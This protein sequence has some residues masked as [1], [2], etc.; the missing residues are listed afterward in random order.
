MV[1]RRLLWRWLWGNEL[2]WGEGGRILLLG[3]GRAWWARGFCRGNS[4]W[5]G[6]DILGDPT[7]EIE[8]GLLVFLEEWVFL[9]GKIK[10]R[11]E[12]ENVRKETKEEEE[13]KDKPEVRRRWT[14]YLPA[15]LGTGTKMIE[16]PP[17]PCLLA[18]REYPSAQSCPAGPR[19]QG[20]RGPPAFSPRPRGK[21]ISPAQAQ[22]LTTQGSRCQTAL[23]TISPEFFRA[24]SKWSQ[25]MAEEFWEK[26]GNT[27][28][29][30]RHRSHPR[31]TT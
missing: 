9:R 16:V 17:R 14:S 8:R 12:E 2:W 25:K 23:N 10:R 19:I 1:W 21:G 22:V 29:H 7:R 18:T 31:H 20:L 3:G 4:Y 24:I 13:S 5:R 6:R 30:V 26:K 28:T 11:K 15:Y 27:H